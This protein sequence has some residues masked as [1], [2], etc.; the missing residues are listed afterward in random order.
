VRGTSKRLSDDYLGIAHFRAR[1]MRMRDL[2]VIGLAPTLSGRPLERTVA[3]AYHAETSLG[4]TFPRQSEF[5]RV[6]EECV[7]YGLLRSPT[8]RHHDLP[9][10]PVYLKVRAA[11]SG[12]DAHPVIPQTGALTMSKFSV[13]GRFL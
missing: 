1:G 8:G 6:R 2:S 5:V 4:D 10:D 3:Y 12:S 13:E 9:A 11:P 7:R